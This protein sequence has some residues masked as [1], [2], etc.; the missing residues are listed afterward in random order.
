MSYCPGFLHLLSK[1]APVN[2]A[3]QGGGHLL[4]TGCDFAQGDLCP[5]AFIHL[6]L[7]GLDFHHRPLP[8]I[9]YHLSGDDLNFAEHL[10]N[11]NVYK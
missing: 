6:P 3:P 11:L 4:E 7:S 10:S 9:H 1:E 5:L 2:V 8:A